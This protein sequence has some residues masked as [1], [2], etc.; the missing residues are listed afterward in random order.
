MSS[1]DQAPFRPNSP[2][3]PVQLLLAVALP[4]G[5]V[6]LSS[7]SWV[8]P[9]TFLIA[10]IPAG[11]ALYLHRFFPIPNSI[12]LIGSICYILGTILS[13][14]LVSS[15]TFDSLIWLV[16]Q[17]LL[18]FYFILL[19]SLV[20]LLRVNET[21]V[22]IL[23]I[24]LA[25]AVN[26]VINV[27][28]FFIGD[29]Q[30]ALPPTGRFIAV[31][32]TPGSKW[33]TAV[34]VTCAVLFS[35]AFALATSSGAKLWVRILATV[36]AV[37]IAVMLI[38]TLGR[39]GYLGVLAGILSVVPFVSRRV[40]LAIAAFLAVVLLLCLYPP[41]FDELFARGMNLRTDI[42]LDYLGWASESP[43]IGQGL[44][45]N[46]HRPVSGRV[47]HHAHNLLISAQVRGGLLSLL[48][49]AL[50]LGGGI[51]WSW[52]FARRSGSPVI[53]AMIVAMTVAGLFDYELLLKPTEWSWVAF[54]LP[55]GLAAGAEL[56]A[57]RQSDRPS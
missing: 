49:M 48:G 10:S 5:A 13:T 25:C 37:P 12:V 54:W 14:V 51:Y 3:V 33:P 53:L 27:A 32:G 42:W 31:I 18:I 50:M 34:S 52:V 1:G 16:W 40:R 6:L 17:S 35:A 56:A 46:I 39:G 8:P 23:A 44:L 43:A 57:R 24:A 38:L 36:A 19:L 20:P 55:I 30:A 29:P 15:P 4:L 41:V 7:L 47:L 22:V 26:A 11:I 45:A 28:L 21:N 2:I 9:A